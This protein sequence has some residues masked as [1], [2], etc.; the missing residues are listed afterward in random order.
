M[1]S[2][3]GGRSRIIKIQMNIACWNYSL[4][5]E[6]PQQAQGLEQLV[7]GWWGCYGCMYEGYINFKRWGH[8]WRKWITRNGLFLSYLCFL[9]L[10]DMINHS[11]QPTTKY[12]QNV[13]CESFQL[14]LPEKV[15]IYIP[16]PWIFLKCLFV[17]IWCE[18]LK[19]KREKQIAIWEKGVGNKRKFSN[20]KKTN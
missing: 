14:H 16:F 9:I 6:C 1:R 3:G 11:R 13:W 5:V 10:P 7:P 19:S 12:F 17:L 18:S 4:N 2:L 20:K 8:S 15:P